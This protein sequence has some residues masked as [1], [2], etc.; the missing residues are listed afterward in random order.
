[1]HARFVSFLISGDSQ[2]REKFTMLAAP[3]P[4]F[5]HFLSLFLSPPQFLQ[6]RKFRSIARPLATNVCPARKSAAPAN[7]L[8]RLDFLQQVLRD[9]SAMRS[10]PATSSASA[11]KI[12]TSF[13]NLVHQLITILSPSPSIFTRAPAKWRI[14]SLLS[15]DK[16]H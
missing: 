6:R 1:M 10:R 3:G 16:P 11:N 9:F 4:N 8:A 5:R 15:P 7:F 2:A 12:G 13:T 14:D